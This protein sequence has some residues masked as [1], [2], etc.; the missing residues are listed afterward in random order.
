MTERAT[1]ASDKGTTWV[2]L[3]GSCALLLAIVAPAALVTAA[4]LERSFSWQAV[5]IAA[6]AG[7][8]CYFAAALSLVATF[9]GN[10]YGYAI[11]GLLLGMLFRMGLPLV[12]LI[13][14]GPSSSKSGGTL[15]ATLVVVYLLALIVDTILA[16]RMTPA[17]NIARPNGETTLSDPSTLTDNLPR[18]T[19]AS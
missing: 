11:Q 2:A 6:M 7:G 4:I 5:S 13:G 15:G 1:N 10:R 17:K 3:I 16:L 9:V 19:V 12:A 14:F 18:P 8:V